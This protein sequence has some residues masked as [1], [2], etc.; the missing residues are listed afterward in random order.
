MSRDSKF[1]FDD[2]TQ[3]MRLIK[4]DR[5]VNTVIGDIIPPSIDPSKVESILDLGCG[6]GGWSLKVGIA[7]PKTHV[8]GVD[9]SE[10]MIRYSQAQAQIQKTSNVEFRLM[11]VL[12]WP[13]DFPDDSFDLIYGRFLVSFVQPAMWVGLLMECW[14]LLKPGGTICLTEFEIA[15]SNN[16]TLDKVQNWI[17][18]VL[19]HM[20]LGFS[21]HHIAI[22][23]VMRRYLKEAGY[24]APQYFPYVIDWSSENIEIHEEQVINLI[25]VLHIMKGRIMMLLNVTEEE[26]E[27]SVGQI[28]EEVE[29]D[30]FCSLTTIYSIV[31]VK[32]EI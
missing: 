6:P 12:Q 15:V 8:M 30:D 3:L 5:T 14:R 9:N 26:F 31:G 32:P 27:R 20:G 22:A 11:D 19:H 7:Y 13:M 16:A 4:Q 2:N 10:L 24:I 18:R 1:D 28:R 25:T 29:H 17:V 21:Q 23:P